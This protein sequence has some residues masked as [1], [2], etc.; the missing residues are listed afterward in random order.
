MHIK[1]SQFDQLLE[2]VITA[3]PE[4]FAAW[5]QKVPIIVEDVPSAKMMKEF[6]VDDEG[7]LLGSFHGLAFTQQGPED[8]GH[9]PPQIYIFREPIMELCESEEELAEEIRITLLHE[10]GHLAGF[11]EDDLDDLGYG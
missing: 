2:Q 3:L 1:R 11:D 6:G 9:L 10:I 8:S 4:Q 7:D 5:L